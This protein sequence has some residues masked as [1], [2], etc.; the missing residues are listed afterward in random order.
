MRYS[1]TQPRMLFEMP[2]VKRKMYEGYHHPDISFLY[3]GDIAWQWW[4]GQM[5]LAGYDPTLSKGEKKRLQEK[6]RKDFLLA[7]VRK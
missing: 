7:K 3:W 2:V 4:Y 5:E 1:M 6:I